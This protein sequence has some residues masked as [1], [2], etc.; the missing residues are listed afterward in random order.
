MEPRQEKPKTTKP[1]TEEKPKRFRI[2][3]LED[4]IAPGYS[5]GTVYT[6]DAR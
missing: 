5:W 1:R 4:R 6:G 3:K 2:V